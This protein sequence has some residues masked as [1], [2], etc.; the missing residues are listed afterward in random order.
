MGASPAAASV[1]ASVALAAGE[2]SSQP[3]SGP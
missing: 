2:V 3:W 1:S